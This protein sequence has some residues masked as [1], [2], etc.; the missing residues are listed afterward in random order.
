MI[1]FRLSLTILYLGPLFELIRYLSH[2]KSDLLHVSAITI[3]STILIFLFIY[4]WA[5]GFKLILLVSKLAHIIFSSDTS[6]HKWQEATISSL[7]ILPLM[8][9]LSIILWLL[10]SLGNF[11]G[12][13]DDLVFGVIANIFGAICYLNIFRSWFLLCKS[14]AT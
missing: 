5:F 9:F 1:H 6:F 2:Q 3:L 10:Y 14:G 12:W 7:N 11:G 8:S 13:P 4:L